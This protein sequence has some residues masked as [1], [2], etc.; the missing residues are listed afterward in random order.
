MASEHLDALE[1]RVKRQQPRPGAFGFGLVVSRAVWHAPPMVGRVEFDL[2]R[3]LGC[4]GG[5]AK[6]V[7]V[8][9]RLLVVVPGDGDQVRG[10]VWASSKCGL[11]ASVVT[12]PPPWKLAAAL[13]L[14]GVAA[15]VRIVNGPPLQ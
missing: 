7:L 2:G 6:G 5:G 4:R 15:A 12:K 11:A 14:P 9:R 8:G 3:A 1:L 13:T 10:L